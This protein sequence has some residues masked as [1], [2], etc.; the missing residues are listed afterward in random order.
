MKFTSM[1]L[2]LFISASFVFGQSNYYTLKNSSADQITDARSIALGES[3]VA[4]PLSPYSFTFN[5][6]NLSQINDI[7]VFYNKRSMNWQDYDDSDVY[8]T[9][10]G[11][12]VPLSIGNI[13]FTYSK[14]NADYKST[15]INGRAA[16]TVKNSTLAF[17]YGIEILKNFS[18]GAAVKFYNSSEDVISE[19]VHIASETADNINAL[20][21]L[22]LLY[23]INTPFIRNND[24]MKDRLNLGTSVQNLGGKVKIKDH[25]YSV[26]SLTE[27]SIVQY[28]RVGFS[29]NFMVLS[30]AGRN[31][32]SF[33]FS[34]EY[35]SMMNP[36]DYEQNETDNLGFGLESTLFDVF[37]VRLG[38][39]TK[40]DDNIFYER[41]EMK[42][43]YG[44]GLNLPLDYFFENTPLKLGFDY[45]VIQLSHVDKNMSAFSLNVRYGMKLF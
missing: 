42:I 4:N 39:T 10:L 8:Y 12:V 20:T 28:F 43:N 22:G 5:P 33:V 32:L 3:F 40:Y 2:L 45:A 34:G 37:S 38:G 11:A 13:A 23:S 21:D 16:G 6:S 30:D 1:M 24:L 25:T 9:S 17:A 29:Y 7:A 15:S 14:Y 36:G 44:F 31:L 26:E 41:G 18:V 27:N 35:R 19:H